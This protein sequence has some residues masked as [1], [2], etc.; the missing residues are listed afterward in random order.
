M[1]Q[2]I[3]ASAPRR[4]KAAVSAPHFNAQIIPFSSRPRLMVGDVVELCRGSYPGN[5]GKLAV[6]TGFDEHGFA[7]I[8]AIGE[9]F[10]VIDLATGEPIE[11]SLRSRAKPENLYR[12]SSELVDRKGR[13]Q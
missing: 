9:Y 5:H 11:T 3:G 4:R 13:L 6:I 1:S 12:R 10:I 2:S 7:L 8:Q